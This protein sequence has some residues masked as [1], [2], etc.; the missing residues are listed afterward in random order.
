MSKSFKHKRSKV[1]VQKAIQ[2]NL[3]I[4]CTLYWFFCLC[5][6][7][8]FVAVASAFSGD[9]KP[10]GQLFGDIW[11]QY[12]VAVL[13]SVFLLPF[14]VWDVIKFSHRVVG[15]LIRLEAEMRK[16]A[17]GGPGRPV[18]FRD[19]DYWHGLAEQYNK[20]VV[21]RGQVKTADEESG[22]T[23]HSTQN[24]KVSVGLATHDEVQ[25]LNGPMPS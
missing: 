14:V 17:E 15:P 16:F 13:A 19:D 9:L 23:I 3:A 8:L 11:K 4:R 24:R 20:I 1:L 7:F 18:R 6:I 25:V 22:V 10:A 5:T 2:G 12:S 21:C